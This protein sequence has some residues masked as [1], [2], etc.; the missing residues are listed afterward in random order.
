MKEYKTLKEK[1]NNVFYPPLP[2]GGDDLTCE[3]IKELWNI[4]DKI[5]NG[6]L[7]ELPC[8]VG[9]DA[10]FVVKHEEG[11]VLEDGYIRAISIDNDGIWVSCYYNSGLSYWHKI[12]DKNLFFNVADAEARLKELQNV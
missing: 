9:G 7:I 1:L 6:T 8:K 5:E 11:Y 3:E 12:K 10:Y 4:L 2:F